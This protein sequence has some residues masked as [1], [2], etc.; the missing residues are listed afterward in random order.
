M[1]RN[2]E[3]SKGHEGKNLLVVLACPP[4]T[5]GA[6]TLA[7]ISSLEAALR[8]SSAAIVNLLNVPSYRTQGMSVAGSEERVWLESRALILKGLEAADLVLLAY[9][10]SEP[11][12][13]ARKWHRD[14][15]RWLQ[16]EINQRSLQTFQVGEGP[17]HPS[18]W[19]RLTTRTHPQED[20]TRA[21]VELL[22]PSPAL[23]L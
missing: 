19:H 8:L 3:F 5:S 2:S 18:R 23:N 21:V 14:Q 17:R 7:R 15:I 10:V 13:P 4:T 12:G 11:S 9:G 1:L 6:R 20:V 22:Q 16:A